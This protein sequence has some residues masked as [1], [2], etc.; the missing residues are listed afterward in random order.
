[1]A[2]HED[3]LIQFTEQDGAHII[4]K[5][6]PQGRAVLDASAP[7]GNAPS[8]RNHGCDGPT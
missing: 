7:S 2:L 1:M 5:A 6:T 3:G 4:A 8:R